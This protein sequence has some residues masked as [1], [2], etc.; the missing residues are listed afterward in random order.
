MGWR[1]DKPL[2]T[3]TTEEQNE[4]AKKTW[5]GESLGGIMEDNNRLPQPVVGLLVLT[6][7]TA[8]LITFPL[9][10]KRPT[11][12]IFAEYVALMDTPAVQAIA[13]DAKK[14]D[15]MVDK[16]R[17]SGSEHVFELDRHPI[18]MDDLRMIKDDIVELQNA[19]VNLLEYSVLGNRIVLANFEGNW[20][21]DGT[22]ERL[23]PWWDKGYVIDIFF[24]VIFCVAV[25][26]T[27]K[28]LPPS[29]FEPDH[30][31]SH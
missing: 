26:I 12:A 15:Y 7:I 28:R 27:I 5:E 19:G 18:T 24:I 6:I 16:V 31:K 29:S 25:T 11:A 9:W 2:E 22:R 30:S 20:K 13:D 23:Q 4:D 14:M 8:F 10:G 3:M 21:P 1:F 17:A